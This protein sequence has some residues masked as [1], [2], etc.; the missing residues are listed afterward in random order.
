MSNKSKFRVK[1]V[2]LSLGALYAAQGQA[3]N[4]TGQINWIEVWPSGNVAFT[5]TGV[6]VPCTL[7]Q[8]IINKS[9]EG[10]KNLYAML[11][12]AKAMGQSIMVSQ[13]TCG[14]ADGGGGG[15]AIVDYLYSYW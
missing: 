10:A 3:A 13:S 14:N 7:Q 12:T 8:F 9:N 6:T 2:L 5:M 11:L 15:Y 4:H 1:A